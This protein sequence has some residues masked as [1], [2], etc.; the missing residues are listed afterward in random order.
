M[1]TTN[2]HMDLMIP[3]QSNK[4]VVFNESL[5]TIDNFM[6]LSI[7]GFI[8]TPPTS[9]AVGEKYIITTGEHKDRICYR[10]HASKAIQYCVPSKGMM[11]YLD[12]AHNFIL[13]NGDEW[14]EINANHNSND[15]AASA[16]ESRDSSSN[17]P[18]AKNFTGINELFEADSTTPYYYLYLNGETSLSFN[19][20][21]LAEITIIIKQCSNAS[22]PLI[23]PDNILWEHKTPHTMTHTANSI[24]IIKLYRLPETTHFLGKII[25]QNFQ[26]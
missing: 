11:F 1:K 13:Y 25:G 19:Q 17:F 10:V 18:V 4:D 21:E 2:F 26:F 5:L 12:E 6:K 14:L 7:N 8:T 16:S 23:W 22:F 3:N 20:A 15:G 24:D 9:L